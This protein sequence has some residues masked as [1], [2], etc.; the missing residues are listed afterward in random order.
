MSNLISIGS[1]YIHNTPGTFVNYLSRN[2]GANAGAR[3]T[4]TM[5]LNFEA[6]KS[7][8]ETEIKNMEEREKRF[9]ELSKIEDW[10]KNDPLAWSDKFLARTGNVPTKSQ[11]ILDKRRLLVYNSKVKRKSA[12][13][14]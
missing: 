11:K 4:E 13:I 6:I 3:K 14:Y 5:K 12:S 2:F 9:Y 8:L 10:D 7:P 1:P